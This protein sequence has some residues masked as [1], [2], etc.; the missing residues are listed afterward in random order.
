MFS[1]VAVVLLSEA[2]SRAEDGSAIVA[3]ANTGVEVLVEDAPASD[4]GDVGCCGVVGVS[5]GLKRVPPAP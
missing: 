4:A 1:F 2:A 3:A 5:A